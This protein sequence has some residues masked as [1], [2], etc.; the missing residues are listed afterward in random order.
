MISLI[1]SS[2]NILKAVETVNNIDLTLP[3]NPNLRVILLLKSELVF[4]STCL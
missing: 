4:Y 3:N 1:T 2:Y